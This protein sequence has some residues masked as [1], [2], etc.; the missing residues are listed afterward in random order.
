[1]M[2]IEVSGDI[3]MAFRDLRN[4]SWTLKRRRGKSPTSLLG[5]E[6]KV[7][8]ITRSKNDREVL[9]AGSADLEKLIG[10]CHQDRGDAGS[11]L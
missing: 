4:C 5:A 11:S 1:M 8:S 10:V 2:N 9:I 7:F 6:E 3:N